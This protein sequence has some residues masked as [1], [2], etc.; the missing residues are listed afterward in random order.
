MNGLLFIAMLSA[1]LCAAQVPPS[2][3]NAPHAPT[4]GGRGG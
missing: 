3:A 1:S 2:P 4:Q